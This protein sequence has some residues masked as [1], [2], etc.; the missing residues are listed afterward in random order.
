L[1]NFINFHCR[2]CSNTVLCLQYFTPKH[3]NSEFIILTDFKKAKT[4]KSYYY[5]YLPSNQRSSTKRRKLLLCQMMEFLDQPIYLPTV[6][7]LPRTTNILI[8][9]LLAHSKKKL[10]E[11]LFI[12]CFD[13][14][15]RLKEL[16]K[17]LRNG[18]FVLQTFKPKNFAWKEGHRHPL[19][20]MG[21]P[22]PVER[23]QKFGETAYTSIM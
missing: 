9:V 18:N 10:F 12:F 4:T 6:T 20:R 7:L 11:S 8:N 13:R 21:D 16:E 22:R 14:V 17:N 19:Q 2:I 23:E 5:R 15:L 1:G 3:S